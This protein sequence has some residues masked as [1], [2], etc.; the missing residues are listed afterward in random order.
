VD[1]GLVIDNVTQADDG[2]YSC[3]AEVE[4]EG[5]FEEK[6]IT[7]AVHGLSILVL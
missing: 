3:R 6:I 7:V 2:D 4:L 1:N 5:R